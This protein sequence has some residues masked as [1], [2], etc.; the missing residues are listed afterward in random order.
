[1]CVCDKHM[2]SAYTQRCGHRPLS[3]AILS[4]G[5]MTHVSW[6]PTL[7]PSILYPAYVEGA[8]NVEFRFEGFG[9]YLKSEEGCDDG[10][11]GEGFEG[12]RVRA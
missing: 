10:V 3:N 12:G 8:C 5:R 6:P 11:K 9:W 4:C 1:M 2:V 7:M